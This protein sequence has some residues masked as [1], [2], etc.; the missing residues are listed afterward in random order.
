[1][2]IPMDFWPDILS[3]FKDFLVFFVTFFLAFFNKDHL[4]LAVAIAA[5]VLSI[6][7]MA[8]KNEDRL[9]TLR[10][11]ISDVVSKLLAAEV[12]VGRLNA[13]IDKPNL[14]QEDGRRFRAARWRCNEQRLSLAQV[15]TYFLNDKRTQRARFVAAAEYAAVARALGDNKDLKGAEDY[16]KKAIENAEPGVYK[17]RLTAFFAEFSFSNIDRDKGRR[18]YECSLELGP[19]PNDALHWEAMYNCFKWAKSEA[20][21]GE[22]K[23]AD[24]EMARA[25]EMCSKIENDDLKEDGEVNIV[26][27]ERADV[28][29]IKARVLQRKPPPPPPPPRPFPSAS[30]SP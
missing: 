14:S 13:E 4:A 9:R 29:R 5:F 21:V 30:A 20:R 11:Q 25:A 17:A 24:E 22:P 6:Y 12:E 26:P 23:K 18:L 16:W 19:K 1:M 3:L 2:S 10:A 27:R 28:E 15:A 8:R 7:G